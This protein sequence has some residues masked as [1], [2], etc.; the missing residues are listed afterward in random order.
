MDA[1]N[2]MSNQNRN[3]LSSLRMDHIVF[4]RISF[5]RTNFS[6]IN[7][8]IHFQARR[9]VEKLDANKYCVS[10][11]VTAEKEN[12]YSAEVDISGYCAVSDDISEKDDLINKNAV[13]ILFPYVRAQFTLL[14]SQPEMLPIV[15]PAMNINAMFGD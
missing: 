7:G 5:E 10:L 12:E 11:N 8:E 6:N 14:T 3:A 13:A 2:N 9:N 1:K 4:N 15:L